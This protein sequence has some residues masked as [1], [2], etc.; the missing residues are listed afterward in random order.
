MKL[1]SCCFGKDEFTL[2]HKLNI[3]KLNNK[4]M[5]NMK[6]ILGNDIDRFHINSKKFFSKILLKY[7]IFYWKF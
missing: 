2:V 6:K 5:Q 7:E 4:Y 3:H 1:L